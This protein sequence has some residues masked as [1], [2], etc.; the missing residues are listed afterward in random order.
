M[1]VVHCPRCGK[2]VG[3]HPS[4]EGKAVACAKCGNSFVISLPPAVRAEYE[5]EIERRRRRM[6]AAWLRQARNRLVDTRIS[7]ALSA[8]AQLCR[9]HLRTLAV[10]TVVALIAVASLPMTRDELQWR[11]ARLHDEPTHYADYLKSWPRGR[12]R[13]EARDRIEGVHW[14]QATAANTIGSYAD[15]LKSWPR[16]RQRDEA[17]DR[18]EGVHW[19]QATAANT[20]RSYRVYTSA[21]PQGKFAQQSQTRATALRTAQEPYDSALR[22]GTEASLRAFLTDYPGHINEAAAQQALRDITEGRDIVDVLQ[23]KKIEV[24]AQGS[25]IERVSVR[26]RRLVPYPL[27]V[28]AV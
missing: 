9:K 26:L 18:I 21:H 7:A 20:I 8:I 3:Y 14:Q 28:R 22:K 15:Y 19:Q 16:G 13:D 27:T 25:G 17:R 12:H 11:V 6:D 2:E 23:E 1:V 4:D 10:I 24:Q 5:R